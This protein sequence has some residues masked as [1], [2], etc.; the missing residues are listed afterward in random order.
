[1][2]K[3]NQDAYFFSKEYGI[4]IVSDG[5]GGHK[6]GEIASQ[7]VVDGLRDAYMASNQILLENV[8]SFLDD[9]LK[10]INAEILRQANADERIH[11]M[12]ATVNYLQFAA[13]TVAIGHAGDSRTYLARILQTPSGEKTC[14]LWQLTVDH[15]VGTFLERGIFKSSHFRTPPTE[16]QKS[17]LTRGM[18]VTCDLSAD[19]YTRTL[20]EDDVLV[21]CSDGLH[22]FVPEEAI[23]DALCS[24]P[25]ADSPQRLIE[26][27]KSVGAPD[28]VTIV[29]SVWSEHEEPLQTPPQTSDSYLVRFPDG[30]IEGPFAAREIVQRWIAGNISFEAEING[31]GSEWVFLRRYRDIYRVYPEFNCPAVR[32]HVTRMAPA[33]SASPSVVK[34]ARGTITSRLRKA[35]THWW[36]AGIMLFI[37]LFVLFYNAWTE[38]LLLR[39]SVWQ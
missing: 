11:G 1:M 24:G 8:G 10:S 32:E 25:I 20:M 28:N 26:L 29:I 27:A 14:A 31:A 21:T 38:Y 22:G 9:V 33:S 3:T 35:S 19:L 12:G 4:V 30:C 16:R 6:G 23:I 34:G 15:N 13:G 5:M 37:I 39:D 2:R 36:L 18:G 7:L 17:R